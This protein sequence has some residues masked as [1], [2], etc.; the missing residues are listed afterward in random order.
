MKKKL[1]FLCTRK[2]HIKTHVKQHAKQLDKGNG[3]KGWIDLVWLAWLQ[4]FLFPGMGL[5]NPFSHGLTSVGNAARL[6]F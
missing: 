1:N 6:A 4:L 3:K 5:E 2:G